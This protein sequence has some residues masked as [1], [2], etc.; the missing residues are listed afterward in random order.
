MYSSFSNKVEKKKIKP[1][2]LNIVKAWA[3]YCGT[4]IDIKRKY[5][6]WMNSFLINYILKIICLRMNNPFSAS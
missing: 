3:F 2:L 6:Q 1:I 4:F 5:I